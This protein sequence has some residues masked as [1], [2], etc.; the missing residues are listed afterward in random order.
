[1]DRHLPEAGSRDEP[2]EQLRHR[3]TDRVVAHRRDVDAVAVGGPVPDARAAV[4][5]GDQIHRQLGRVP[6]GRTVVEQEAGGVP[7]GFGVCHRS[8]PR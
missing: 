7:Q 2:A 8:A 5:A 4:T 3:G 1:M 6:A